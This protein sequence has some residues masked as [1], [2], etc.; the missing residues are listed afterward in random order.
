MAKQCLL[1]EDILRFIL[2]GILHVNHRLSRV[3]KHRVVVIKYVTHLLSL[4]IMVCINIFVMYNS[5]KFTLLYI[6]H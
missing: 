1:A 2:F 5:R 4:M 3:I 6:T